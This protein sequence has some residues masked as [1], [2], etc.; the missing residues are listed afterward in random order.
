MFFFITSI[1][2]PNNAKNYRVI[3]DLLQLTISSVCSQK[4]QFKFKF[5]IVCN[6]MPNIKVDESIVEFLVVDFPQPGDGKSI[7]LAFESV[8]K[9][10]GSK[11]AAGLAW[12]NQYNPSKVF[13]IDADDWVNSNIVE[14]VS[15]NSDTS[16]WYVDTGYLINLAAKK[17]TQ[18]HGLCRY[19]GST[20]IYDYKKLLDIIEYKGKLGEVLSQIEII[21]NINDFG[22]NYILGDHRRQ[23]GYFN[24]LNKKI[25]P[26]PFKAICWVLDTGENHSGKTGGTQGVPVTSTMLKQFGINSL[27][28]LKRRAKLSERLKEIF[29]KTIS[30]IGWAKTD[31]TADKV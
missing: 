5:L 22:M 25:A 29:A 14:Y 18:K 20:Y 15:V 16:F 21:E 27:E 4:T 10:K 3:L 11:L 26:L 24:K 23:L 1:R 12:I 30:Y 7:E 9:D 8:L 2:H 6:E 28:T 17:S 13:I 31:K 19:C